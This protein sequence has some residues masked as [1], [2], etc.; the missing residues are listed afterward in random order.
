MGDGEEVK[1]M[2]PFF[3]KKEGSISRSVVSNECLQSV[4]WVYLRTGNVV[5]SGFVHIFS[6][7]MRLK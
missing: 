7:Q 6:F 3:F 5:V 1:R 2:L 4:L